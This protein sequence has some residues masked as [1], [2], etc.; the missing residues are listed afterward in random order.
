MR[1]GITLIA[2]LFF[3][4][5]TQNEG[6]FYKS[7]DEVT[8]GFADFSLT[9]QP[10]NE[11]ELNIELASQVDENEAGSVVINKKKNV[12][13]KWTLENDIFSYNLDESKASIDSF[14]QNTAYDYLIKSPPIQIFW[15]TDTAYIYGIPCKRISK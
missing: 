10:N 6:R 4:S 14:F 2:I 9:L 11:L 12:K 15:K 1:Y 5:C 3:T 7:T 8:G 13:G